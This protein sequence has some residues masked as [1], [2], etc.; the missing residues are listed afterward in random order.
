MYAKT[1]AVANQKGGVGKTTTALNLA[2]VLSAK[3]KKVLL[4]DSDPQG[5]ASSGVGVFDTD[6]GANIYT[7]YTDEGQAKNCVQKT[8]L[9]NLSVL[10][11]SIDLVGV[12]VELISQENR[13][14]KLKAVLRSLKEEF[15]FIIIDCPPSLGILTLNSLTAA[16]SILIPLQCEYF[17]LEGL[18]Q[19]ISTIRRVKKTLNRELYIEGLLLTM[20]DGRNKLTHSV[21][22]EVKNHF[23][24]QVYKT[25][26]PRNVRLSESPSHGQTI[27]EYDKSSSGAKA[28]IK[29]G[30]E[31]LQR[32]KREM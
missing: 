9:K 20:Y 13:E 29:L 5:N 10:P 12:E 14:K 18:A 3:R 23:G 25:V 24:D 1:I 7:C 4:V 21:A 27:I 11:S 15:D 16:D 30:T 6:G 32:L 2:A 28:Y 19:L 8:R 31:F 22:E 17:A 26:I